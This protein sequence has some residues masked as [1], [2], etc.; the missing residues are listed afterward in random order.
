MYLGGGFAGERLNILYRDSVGEEEILT[1][2]EPIIHDYALNRLE[3][4]HFGDFVIRK[5]IVNT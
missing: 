1:L 2:L 3:N 5:K 4:E